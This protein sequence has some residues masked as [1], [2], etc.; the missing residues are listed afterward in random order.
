MEEDE[1]RGFRSTGSY[2]CAEC[3]GDGTLGGVVGD[4][5]EDEPCSYCGSEP[6]ASLDTVLE[7]MLEGIRFEYRPAAEESPPWESAEGGYQA[8]QVS[9][10]ELLFEEMDEDFGD[11]RVREDL[12]AALLPFDDAW[13]ERD[14]YALR[15]HQQLVY[16]WRRFAT[17]VQRRRTP[18]LRP[19]ARPSDDPDVRAEPEEMLDVLADVLAGLP[20]AIRTFRAGGQIWRGRPGSHSATAAGLGPA[21]AGKP[22]DGGRMNQPG[23]ILFYGALDRDTAVREVAH[24]SGAALVTV[25]PFEAVRDLT[26]LDLS[27]SDLRLP[28]VFDIAA[29]SGR[30]T[31]RFLHEFARLISLPAA[32]KHPRGYFPTQM[33]TEYVRTELGAHVGQ[34]IDGILYPSARSAGS[35][36]VLFF[37]A[38][39]CAD[40]GSA[41]TGVARLLLD[42]SGVAEVRTA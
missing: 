6:S 14:W 31:V 39:A 20:A 42:A 36:A 9:F 32:D 35:N 34:P 41:P 4:A 29:Q 22:V 10:P 17:A 25:G 37:G 8:R 38:E 12:E 19:P 13:F 7:H 21:P 24:K 11:D 30:T 2:V 23:Q 5:A 16:S 3:I 28:S 1:A 27:G 18:L 40:L 15:P 33:V 26:F